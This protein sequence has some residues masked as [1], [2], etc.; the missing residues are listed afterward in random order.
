L[1]PAREKVR[2]LPKKMAQLARVAPN[3]PKEEGGGDLLHPAAIMRAVM[4]QSN[5]AAFGFASII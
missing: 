4:L 3:P 2:I 1:T 5:A